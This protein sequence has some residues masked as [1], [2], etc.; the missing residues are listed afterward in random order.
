[1]FSLNKT[2]LFTSVSILLL[3]MAC[4]AFA[5]EIVE[6]SSPIEKVMGT[7]TGPTGKLISILMMAICGVTYWIRKDDLEG[8]FKMLLGVV[9]AISFI[10][11][12]GSIV[13]NVFSGQF[14]AGA[15]I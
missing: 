11:F 3:L 12:A 14:T 5:S 7:I 2:T 4:P 15:L 10:A 1:M 13:D 9:F 8:G 6:F